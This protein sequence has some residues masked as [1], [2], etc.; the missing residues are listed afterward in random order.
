MEVAAE[1]EAVEE[2]VGV[3]V[4]VEAVVGQFHL[5]RGLAAGQLQQL[6]GQVV[7]VHQQSPL[8]NYLPDDRKAA[9]RGMMSMA[10]STFDVLPSNEVVY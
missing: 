9:G 1:A 8:V 5:G 4:E 6:T 3:Q 2:A 7:G 10:Q